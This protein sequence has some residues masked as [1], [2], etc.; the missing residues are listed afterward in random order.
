[1]K[2]AYAAMAENASDQM[3]SDG[4]L[5]WQRK[6]IMLEQRELVRQEEVEQ[7]RCGNQSYQNENG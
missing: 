4:E 7:A 6:E 5:V 2:H 3:R 1:M